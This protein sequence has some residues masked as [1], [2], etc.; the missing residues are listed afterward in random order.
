M[1]RGRNNNRTSHGDG[2]GAIH[3]ANM[4]I[5]KENDFKEGVKKLQNRATMTAELLTEGGEIETFLMEADPDNAEGFLLAQ[6]N[7]LKAIAEGNAKQ[8]DE[9][10]NFVQAV[11]DVRGDVQRQNQSGAAAGGEGEAAAA[12]ADDPPDY[13]RSIQEAVEKVRLSKESNPNH[14]PLEEHEM[15][16]SLREKLGE[17]VKKRA[18]NDDDDD[19]EI[20]NNVGSD[21]V[22]ALKCPITG[23]FFED[24]VRNK[25]C[26]HTYDRKGLNQLF[27]TRKTKCPIPGCSNNTLSL[28]QVEV[29]DEMKLK[30]RRHKTREEA[31]K[32]KRDL[33]E[34][35]DDDEEGGGYTVLE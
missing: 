15:V 1:A 26:G 8:W 10:E 3:S 24:P 28:G 23:M 34:T 4:A 27:S 25:V 13:E 5:N 12:G 19:L 31:A 30:V 22:H 35:M 9:I 16:M 18:R 6:R 20:V 29:D 11:K 17:K 21:D 14:V 7:R 2:G 33:D 32:K